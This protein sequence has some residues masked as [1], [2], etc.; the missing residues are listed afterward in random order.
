[1][2]SITLNREEVALKIQPQEVIGTL[3]MAILPLIAAKQAIV[4]VLGGIVAHGLGQGMTATDPKVQAPLWLLHELGVRAISVEVG[5]STGSIDRVV[6][7]E[8]RARDTSDPFSPGNIATGRAMAFALSNLSSRQFLLNGEVR[9]I[10]LLPREKMAAAMQAVVDMRRLNEPI[11]ITSTRAL[12]T[13]M[14]SGAAKDDERVEA[15]VALLSDLGVPG[16]T[17]DPATT[18]IT[19]EGLFNEANVAASAYLQG[20]GA[21][22]VRAARTRVQYLNQQANSS[23]GAAPARPPHTPKGRRRR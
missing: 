14:A 4:G 9:D 21:D 10:K 19:F 23:S 8:E 5:G 16:V 13:L 20:G 7:E 2:P 18:T 12:A 3:A 6:P 1:M 22:G 11:H 15:V 17:V